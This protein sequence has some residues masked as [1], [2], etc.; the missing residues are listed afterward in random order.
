[1]CVAMFGL[2]DQGSGRSHLLPS[3]LLLLAN[4]SQLFL[5]QFNILVL[6]TEYRVLEAVVRDRRQ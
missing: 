6:S 5:N 2:H 1:M 3:T 4:G